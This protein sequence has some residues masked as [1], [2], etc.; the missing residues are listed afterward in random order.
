MKTKHT[1]QDESE[2]H[3]SFDHREVHAVDNAVNQHKHQVLKFVQIQR[4]IARGVVMRNHFPEFSV[5]RG[6][7]PSNALWQ[8]W[9]TSW[10]LRDRFAFLPTE[11][12]LLLGVRRGQRR[13]AVFCEWKVRKCMA[14][15]EFGVSGPYKYETKQ[16]EQKT[17]WPHI[18]KA[19]S[20][21]NDEGEEVISVKLDAFPR[22]AEL[23]LFERIEKE[24]EEEA[25]QG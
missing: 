15:K 24:E 25:A 14:N 3:E 16:G 17:A 1:K 8:A 13:T 5:R 18:G 19:W 7:V 4:A 23:V 6:D 9:Q 12:L 10:L 20:R 11:E 21:I 22:E 2:D